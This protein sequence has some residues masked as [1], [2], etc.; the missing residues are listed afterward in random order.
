MSAMQKTSLA[1][2]ISGIVIIIVAFRMSE[3][4]DRI[5]QLELKVNAIQKV[6]L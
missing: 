2:V 5:D 6:V 3:L 1:I 4:R